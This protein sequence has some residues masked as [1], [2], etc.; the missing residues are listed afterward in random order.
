MSDP[1]AC[2]LALWACIGPLE[3]H[4][5]QLRFF[6]VV[7]CREFIERYLDVVVCAAGFVLVVRARFEIHEIVVLIVSAT[8]HVNRS[9]GAIPTYQIA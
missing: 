5:Q 6:S 3:L 8:T 4:R 7:G 9:L 1:L 2:A